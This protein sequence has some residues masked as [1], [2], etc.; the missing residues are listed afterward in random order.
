MDN[1]DELNT[2]EEPRQMLEWTSEQKEIDKM[3]CIIAS[4]DDDQIDVYNYLKSQR[5]KQCEI[6]D[7]VNN[8]DFI[9]FQNF[10]EALDE[11]AYTMGERIPEW[12]IVD[13]VEMWH[14]LLSDYYC[15][16]DEGDFY[17]QIENSRFM[18]YI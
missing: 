11:L 9:I 13:K 1:I 12:I 5:V 7:I 18:K 16:I 2:A 14:S 8:R 10:E 4:W 17:W 3:E 15:M 6:M